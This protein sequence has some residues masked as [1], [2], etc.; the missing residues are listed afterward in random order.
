MAVQDTAA[1]DSA[2]DYVAYDGARVAM[3]ALGDPFRWRAV[4][5]L[6][7]ADE[8]SLAVLSEGAAIGKSTVSYHLRMLREAGLISLRKQ[9]RHHFVRLNRP[10]LDRVVLLI[11]AEIG[12]I[13][14]LELSA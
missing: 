10:E 7:A 4:Q 11:S 5:L 14:P 3:R 8:V 6:G 1:D 2:A 12:R 9:G 13:V